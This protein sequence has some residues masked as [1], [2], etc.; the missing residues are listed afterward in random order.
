MVINSPISCVLLIVLLNNQNISIIA[1]F[2]ILPFVFHQV[3]CIFGIHVFVADA[4]SKIHSPVKRMIHLYIN[5]RKFTNLNE[6][7]FKVH[8]YIMAF[9]TKKK[10]GITYGWIGL[11]TMSSFVKF[12]FLYLEGLLYNFNLNRYKI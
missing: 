5:D 4:N 11:I 9:H 8:N 2:F 7:K 6:L 12:I 1:K 10:Y 3:N